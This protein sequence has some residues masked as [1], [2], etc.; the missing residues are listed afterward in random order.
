MLY[1][2]FYSLLN[3]DFKFIFLYRVLYISREI[4]EIEKKTWFGKKRKIRVWLKDRNRHWNF[5]LKRKQIK[6]WNWKFF[7]VFFWKLKSVENT[8]KKTEKKLKKN[9]FF[10]GFMPKKLK[11]VNKILKT[12]N[13]YWK[14]YLTENRFRIDV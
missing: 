7:T 9:F 5:L 3:A 13:F 8:K 12:E 10:Q 2:P 11:N 1:I 6:H 4:F 14:L